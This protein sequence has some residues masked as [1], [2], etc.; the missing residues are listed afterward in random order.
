MKE[1]PMIVAQTKVG[2]LVNVKIW[3]NK[4]LINKRITLGRLETSED[5]KVTK[6]KQV[7]TSRIENLKI[8]VRS[9]KKEDIATRGLPSNTTGV[10]I[11][12]I[13]NDSPIADLAVNNI[14][15]EAQKRKIKTP[16]DLDNIIKSAVMAKNKSIVIVIYNNQNQKSYIGVKLN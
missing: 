10:V 7:K 16:G 8:E 5:F 11:T 1:L 14:I 15:V 3:R 6:P 12:K 13:D 4:K 9:L 2:K